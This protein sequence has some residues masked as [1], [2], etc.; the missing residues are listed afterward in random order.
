MVVLVLL[1]SVRLVATLLIRCEL[2]DTRLSCK[3]SAV[4]FVPVFGPVMSFCMC[5]FIYSFQIWGYKWAMQV[6]V[7]VACLLPSAL[8]RSHA[9]RRL[10]CTGVSTRAEM[11]L[12]FRVWPSL[13][14]VDVFLFHLRCC[15]GVL[16]DLSDGA[17]CM[18]T[19]CLRPPDVAS[20]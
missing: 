10:D 6:R 8:T 18:P 15:G 11:A 12:L 9:G 1:L 20:V 7:P 16:A 3:T 14:A 2:A 13:H 4:Y 19:A 5:C 17:S